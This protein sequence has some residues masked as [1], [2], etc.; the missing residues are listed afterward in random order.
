M[1]RGR[2]VSAADVARQAGV[3]R[4]AVS[5]T[6]TPGACVSDAV[7][8]R[9]EMAARELGYHV[10]RMAQSLHLPQSPLVG[11]IGAN[12]AS[13][14]IAAQLDA[15][16]AALLREGLHCLLLN[17]AGHA[18]A[19]LRM[20][21]EYRVRAVV[22]LSGAAPERLV[23]ECAANGVRMVLINR[24]APAGPADLIAADSAA[25]G[26]LAADRL[27]QA[28]CRDVAVIRSGSRTSAKL[29]RADAFL[30]QMQA[31]GARVQVWDQGPNG[32]DTGVAA[33]RALLPGSGIDGAFGVTDDIALGFLNT[34]RH[35]LGLAVPGTLSVIGFDDNP[36][37]A[38]ASHH[39]TTIRQPIAALTEATLRALL[40][41]DSAPLHIPVPVEL[42]ERGSVGP[43]R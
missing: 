24:P 18:E 2:F 22:M 33:A 30:H 15:L 9:V 25:G 36:A 1:T 6:F 41:P 42:V 3:S 27:L 43:R 32:Y 26:R 7:R 4:S 38:W 5:R 40:S 39:L 23:A 17:T 31:A 37:A 35:E 11:V 20:L 28:G 34:A 21:L 12:L 8:S 10:N 29:A 14:Y 16:S 13:S 19:P